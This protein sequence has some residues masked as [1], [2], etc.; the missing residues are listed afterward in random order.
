MNRRYAFGLAF[1]LGLAGALFAC[2]SGDPASPA[3]PPVGDGGTVSPDGAPPPAAGQDGAPPPTDAGLRTFTFTPAALPASGSELPDP[4]RGQ[5]LWLGV[6]AEPATWPDVDAYQRW[7]WAELEPTHGAFAWKLIDDQI[8]AATARKGRFGMRVMALCQGCADHTYKNAKT[9]MPD[10]LADAVNPLVGKAPGDTDS[11]LIPDWNSDAYFTRLTEL[12]TAIGARYK[13]DPHFAWVDVSSYGNWGEMHL[14]PF[15]QPGGPYDT[16][17]QKPITDANAQRL[18]QLN[19]KAFAGKLLV[20]NS[21]Q[22]AALAA[23]VASTSPR[24][25]LRVDCLGSDDLAG[26]AAALGGV[27]G[28][29]DLWKTAPFVTEWCQTNLGSSGANLFVQGE[30]QVRQYHVSMLSSGNFASLPATAAEQTAFRTANVESGY[31]LRATSVSVGL[32]P[33]GSR[34]VAVSTAWANDNVAPT[35]L[36]WRVVVGFRGAS[37]SSSVEAPL[38][39]DLR[40]ALPG[41]PLAGAETVL[42]PA[43]LA[44]G[45]YAVYLRVDDVQQVSPPMQLAMPGRGADGAYVLGNVTIP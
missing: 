20:V 10:D 34:Q 32:D 14:Y 16:S 26:G 42:L 1:A 6:P 31:R 29:S 41:A 43:A 30:A 25:G 8:A 7:S 33:N 18:V 23:A 13:D 12:L 3:T 4:L 2:G 44:P 11:Y 15:T 36:A 28:A 19:A 35:Y 39:L 17:T 40:G 37:G 9:S 24:I 45:T 38:T 21:E 5:Y 22:K 27:P